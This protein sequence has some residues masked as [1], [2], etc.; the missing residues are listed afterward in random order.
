[1][2]VLVLQHIACEPPGAFEDVLLPRRAEG[3]V[4]PDEEEPLPG[5]LI[6]IDAV[7]AMG[8]PVSVNGEAD[9]PVAGRREGARA[10]RRL[11]FEPLT[12]SALREA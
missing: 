4:E 7:I 10:P 9:H 8:G 3:P 12:L 1:M 2:N 11:Y 5:S 6:G